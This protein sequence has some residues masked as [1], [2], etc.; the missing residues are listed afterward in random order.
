V[1]ASKPTIVPN[2]EEVQYMLKRLPP[3]QAAMVALMSGLGLRCGALAT[4]TI[5]GGMFTCYSKGK[6]L[7]GVIPG[8][9]LAFLKRRVKL[10][11]L[12]TGMSVSAIKRSINYHVSKM[13]EKGEIRAR[14][15]CHDFRHFFAIREYGKDKDI[16][17]V[18]KLLNHTSLA[19][20]EKYLKG[21][22]W[23]KQGADDSNMMAAGVKDL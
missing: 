10:S 1:K 23:V 6:V 3:K 12:F 15:S 19:A 20:T 5:K 11:N 4:L 2:E 18:S 14:Y 16:W 22:E 13:F 9:L 7:E 17:R 21:L 8:D